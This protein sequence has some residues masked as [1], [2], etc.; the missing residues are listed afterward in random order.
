MFIITYTVDVDGTVIGVCNCQS[1]HGRLWFKECQIIFNTFVTKD[2]ELLLK[3]LMHYVG[4][5]KN[6]KIIIE[7]DLMVKS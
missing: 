3:V 5:L 1:P 2:G 7:V 6:V 4:S